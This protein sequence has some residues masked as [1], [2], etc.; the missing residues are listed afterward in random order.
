MKKKFT[1]Y[2]YGENTGKLVA[3]E[4]ALV[5]WILANNDSQWELLLS[6]NKFQ[7]FTETKLST[8][9]YLKPRR[10]SKYNTC[11]FPLKNFNK[12][13]IS[14][15]F[16]SLDETN[17]IPSKYTTNKCAEINAESKKTALVIR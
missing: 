1:R 12:L 3:F 16:K 14:F 4:V 7:Q 13:L 8:E 2:K 5:H 6:K 17:V 10:W 11:G 15:D 9:I